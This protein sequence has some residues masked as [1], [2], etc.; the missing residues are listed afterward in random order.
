MI[1]KVKIQAEEHD[2]DYQKIFNRCEVDLNKKIDIPPI[3]LGIGYHG[4]SGGQYLNPTFTYG[5][6]STIVGPQKTKKTFF[7]CAIEACY[8]G[9]EASN[10]FPGIVSNRDQNKW[11]FSFDT[12]QGE[13]YAQRTFKTVQRMVGLPCVNYKCFSLKGLSDEEMLLFIDGVVNDPK[14]KGNIGWISIDGI[15]DLC[16]N[17]ND[18][19]RSKEIVKKLESYTSQGIHVC[20]IIHK[21]FEKDRATG[22]LGSFVQKKS[23]TVIFLSDTDKDTIN[24]PIKVSQKDSRGA[25][26]IDFYFDLDTNKII[27]KECE[28]AQ[29]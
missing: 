14:Y 22:H 8:I 4:Y 1:E 29:W 17:T 6:M 20:G 16:T 15:A 19:V 24:A 23:E 27:P 7:K 18:L 26:F 2:F 28:Q 3:A 25:P 5:E 10:Y 11:I 21:T 13:Y 9:G 12:E